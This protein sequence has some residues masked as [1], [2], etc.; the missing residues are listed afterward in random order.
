MRKFISLHLVIL[1]LVCLLLAAAS[2]TPTS[3]DPRPNIIL[4]LTDDQDID[5]AATM[6]QLQSL[7]V[8]QG[9]A[10]SNFFVNDAL[11]CPSRASI[12]RGQTSDNTK[13]FEN[14][15]AA[16][17][18]QTFYSRGEE[19][20]TVATWLRAAGYRTVLMGKYLNGYPGSA[21]ATY[22][23]P[24][25]S[26]W[27]VPT[28]G[29][30][31]TNAFNA[32]FNYT[33]NENGVRRDYGSSTADYGT[34][35]L[36][37]KSVDFIQRA[38]AAGEPFFM[39]IAPVAPHGSVDPDPPVPAPRHANLFPGA[40]APRLPNF[41]E[42]DVSDKP[43]YVR[44]TPPL[45]ADKIATA[46][47]WQRR[48]LQSLQAVDDL[49][50]SLVSVLAETGQTGNTY[51]FF[52][53]D[54][55]F[56]LGQHRLVVGKRAPYEEDI[57]VPLFVVGPGLPAGATRA[58][59][60]ANI[61]LAPTFA[62]LA[63]VSPP[64]FVDGR[65]LTPLLS[66]SPPAVSSWRQNLLLAHG[67]VPGPTP[68]TPVPSSDFNVTEFRGLRTLALT[69]AGYAGGE[70]ELYDLAADPYQ[71]DSQ[72]TR[73]DPTYL[74]TLATRVAALSTCTGA[75]C[76]PLEDTPLAPLPP[77][78]TPS[79]TPSS[80][81]TASQTPTATQTPTV[82]QTPTTTP[83]STLTPT[84]TKTPTATQT[85]T[86]TGTPTTTPTSTLTPTA[87]K[88][89]TVT[90]T[91]TATGTPT[92][93]PTPTLTPTQ[94]PTTT[95]TFTLT[96][97]ATDTPTAIQTPTTTPTPTLTPT[98]GSCSAKPS[99]PQRLLPG[100]G[101]TVL[102]RNVLLDWSDVV[103]ATSYKVQVR[104]GSSTGTQVTPLTDTTASQFTTAALTTGQT[105]AWQ[106]RS[107]NA[108]GCQP[109][110]WWSFTVAASA[111]TATP[112]RTP[113]RTATPTHTST[114]TQALTPTPTDTPTSTPTDT[115]TSTPTDTPTSTPTDT[116][117]STPTDTPT[118]TPT[119]APTSTPSPTSSSTPS[120]TLTYTPS[121]TRTPTRTPTPGSGADLIFADS[122]E[123]G[124]V[125]AWTSSVTDG[126][127]LS[128]NAA[129]AMKGSRG[130]QAVID[131]NT[132]L[133]VR[134]TRP[135]DEP[136]YRARFYFDPNSIVMT[137]GD[138]H[139]IFT[140][141]VGTVDVF[142]VNF[143]R[144]TTS[145]QVRVQ[146]RTDAATY[147]SGSWYTISDGPHAIE[148]E[149]KAATAAGANNGAISLWID[150]VAKQTK[151][152]IDNDTLRVDEARLGPLAGI[153]TGTR[154]I[155][156]FDAFESRRTGYIGQSIGPDSAPAETGRGRSR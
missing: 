130:M 3:S 120:P 44:N 144:Y 39:Y 92:T 110:A 35:V 78:F 91:P 69:Y 143:R 114:P 87:T 127:D 107:C 129:A 76:Q 40:Q 12:L 66:V 52:T 6:P 106:L 122:F 72:I 93:T 64:S 41:D 62:Q 121:P 2:P 90:L 34:D 31:S 147:T 155:L 4:I 89:P 145:Y 134:D 98:P 97:T 57:H 102:V 153:D 21:G 82:T 46:D 101:A 47:L 60:T 96:P 88:T 99:A 112:T 70:R 30:Y 136:R 29:T 125:S 17:G 77:T 58:H 123:S 51:I 10:F 36:A 65:S 1:L 150:G 140:G 83:T 80:T 95:P 84:A 116:P 113:T 151:G 38:A 131:D 104:L 49:I 55:G 75:A 132:A 48:R 5:S 135:A 7:I 73:T 85:P 100:N 50:A 16:G 25:W 22:I 8:Q 94:T 32:Q 71:L 154:G 141:R 119:E 33:L 56:S 81:P 53:S 138:L 19:S 79:P 67:I 43:G 63:G 68:A 124:S 11:C 61:D 20:S 149:W 9:V 139:D 128:V 109:S 45:S 103:C 115:P 26:E 37:A 13:V 118:S 146:I 108:A 15:P 133:Y 105:Y 137:S 152:S 148:I 86:A 156:Y 14:F 42:A 54:N 28:N 117:T 24:G 142:R 126:G 74:S 23:P 59:L 18:F 111:V 27:Y